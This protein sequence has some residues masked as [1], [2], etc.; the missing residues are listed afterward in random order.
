M[1]ETENMRR[2]KYAEFVQEDVTRDEVTL[3]R[4]A[5]QRGQL[6]GNHRFVDE[7]EHILGRRI[8]MRGQG[9]PHKES[10]VGK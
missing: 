8:E 2:K 4:Q 1:G 5:L 7:V 6:T 10:N 9:R 3:I